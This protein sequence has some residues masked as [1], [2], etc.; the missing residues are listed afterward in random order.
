MATTE[1]AWSFLPGTHTPRGAALLGVTTGDDRPGEPVIVVMFDLPQQKFS[2]V[3]KRVQETRDVDAFLRDILPADRITYP[4]IANLD[5]PPDVFANIDGKQFGIEATQF[6]PPDQ[7]LDKSVSIVGRWM[8]FEKLR[9][10]ILRD[11]TN[12]FAQHQGTLAVINFGKTGDTS[13]ERLPPKPAGVDSV[14][15]ELKSVQPILRDGRT[16]A[17]PPLTLQD[18]EV[19][20]WSAD[21]SCF[22]TWTALPPWYTSRFYDKMGFE[23][24]LGYYVTL[25][26]TDLRKELRRLIEDHDNVETETLVV[27]VNAPVRTGWEFPTNALMAK[28]LFDDEQPLNGWAPSHIKRIALHNQEHQSVKWILGS[29]PWV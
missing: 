29:N 18:S 4:C 23:L 9:D 28:M 3:D 8:L 25:T 22:F 14:V 24:A 2:P 1:A 20:R 5:E 15:E 12:L 17:N 21:R 6:L 11:E 10:K 26:Q 19:L 16:A 7:D 13:A 27:T